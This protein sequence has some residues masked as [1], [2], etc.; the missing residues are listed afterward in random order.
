MSKDAQP[1]VQQPMVEAKDYEARS[2]STIVHFFLLQCSVAK[3][4]KGDEKMTH[5]FLKAFSSGC[6]F[7]WV[8]E[9]A[10]RHH[11]HA[12]GAQTLLGCLR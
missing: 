5:L 3:E 4:I 2:L 7:E 8:N 11:R 10:L 12:P 6:S 9:L 1:E